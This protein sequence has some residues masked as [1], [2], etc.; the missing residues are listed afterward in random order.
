MIDFLL[1]SNDLLVFS[2]RMARIGIP[3][4]MREIA[5]GDSNP[6]PVAFLEDLAGIH[7][8]DMEL[9]DF[10]RRKKHRAGF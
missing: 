4:Y 1:R 10:P 2:E 8:A 9:I 5:A 6:Y 7:Q 3:V